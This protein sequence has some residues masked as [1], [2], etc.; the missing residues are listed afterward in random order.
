MEGAQ[1]W[2]VMTFDY[3]CLALVHCARDKASLFEVVYMEHIDIEPNK[4]K[5]SLEEVI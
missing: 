5:S 2:S 1:N 3:I 4:A